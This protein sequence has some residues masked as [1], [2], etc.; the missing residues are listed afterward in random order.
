MPFEGMF[1]ILGLQKSD[2]DEVPEVMFKVGE[3][4]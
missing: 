2:L 1:Y 3:L 4:P